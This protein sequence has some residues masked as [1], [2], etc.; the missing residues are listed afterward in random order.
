MLDIKYIR[1][2]PDKVRT[3]AKN[4]KVDVDIEALLALDAERR[5]LQSKI[6]ETNRQRNEASKA[7]DIENGKR[8]KQELA[9]LEE[10]IAAV[11]AQMQPVML[12]LPNVPV[13][14]TPV[15]PDESGN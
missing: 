2:N 1:E 10:K 6:E 5:S 14:G 3:A 11:D 12:K 13:D 8:L 9:L 4:K 15:G 7:K